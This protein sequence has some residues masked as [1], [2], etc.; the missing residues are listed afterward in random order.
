MR[1]V[2]QNNHIV[3]STVTVEAVGRI[4]CSGCSLCSLICPT[5]S[6]EMKADVEGFLQP[7]INHDTCVNCGVCYRKCPIVNDVSKYHTS[8]YYASAIKNKEKLLRSSSGGIF[9]ALAEHFIN[10]GGYVCGC[11]FDESMKAVHVCT[12]SMCVVEKM[13]GSKYVQS[14]LSDCLREAK[15]IIS[16]G[17]RVLFTGTA[18][19]IAAAKA[20]FNS[21]SLLYTVDILCHGV[22]SPL[23]LSK[24]VSFLE[25]KHKGQLVRLEFRNKQEFGW[26]AEHRTYY[27]IKNNKGINGYRPKLPAYFCAFFWSLNL[28]ESCYNCKFAGKERISDITIGDFWGYWNYFKHQFPEGIS[29]ASVNSEKGRDLFSAISQELDFMEEVPQD[30]ATG[31]NTNFYHPTLRPVTRDRFYKN[32]GGMNYGQFR[33]RI[34]FDKTSRMS[35]ITSLY[36]RFMP[37]SIRRFIRSLFR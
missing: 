33:R 9:Y 6:I 15:T 16:R 5:E 22:P 12:N 26:G 29:I 21:E 31:T 10:N 8:V 18:C 34:F 25:H 36:G 3:D 27:E 23:F 20:F 28:R 2:T 4:N 17:K 32:I 1:N 14:S 19:Q 37:E 24:Y 35:L 7:I 30:S 11:V 13:M